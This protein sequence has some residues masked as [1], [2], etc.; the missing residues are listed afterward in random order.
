V[1]DN[2]GSYKTNA[3]ACASGGLPNLSTRESG[4]PFRTAARGPGRNSSYT[5]WSRILAIVQRRQPL[6]FENEPALITAQDGLIGTGPQQSLLLSLIR[7]RINDYR[8]QKYRSLHASL[9]RNATDFYKIT[10]TQPR[11]NR[12]L[13][14]EVR[15]LEIAHHAPQRTSR[16]KFLRVA[17]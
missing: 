15:W 10:I 1:E 12:M 5:L 4:S 9:S 2:L 16:S 7:N 11:R 14:N 8:T 6:G 17:F 13:E 3:V